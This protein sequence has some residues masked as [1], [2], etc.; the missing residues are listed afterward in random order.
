MKKKTEKKKYNERNG[1]KRRGGGGRTVTGD[2]NE[3]P[4]IASTRGLRDV[5]CFR[6]VVGRENNIMYFRGFGISVPALTVRSCLLRSVGARVIIGSLM[7]GQLTRVPAVP[8]PRR[9]NLRVPKI[10]GR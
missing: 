5:A 1:D 3:I 8:A 9:L 10:S 7:N 4:A 2:R 6:A